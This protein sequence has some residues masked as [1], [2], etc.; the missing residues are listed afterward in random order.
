MI[1]IE[2]LS[3]LNNAHR[4]LKAYRII[5]DENMLKIT[6]N[7]VLKIQYE[8][9]K[10]DLSKRD[11]DE[12]KKEEGAINIST[13]IQLLIG[14]SQQKVQVQKKM[15]NNRDYNVTT[16]TGIDVVSEIS[17]FFGRTFYE[18]DIRTCNP[19]LIYAYCGLDLP[20]N[21]YGNNKENKTAINRILNTISKDFAI[22]WK[23]GVRKYK[24]TLKSKMIKFNFDERVIDFLINTF[25]EK[26]KDAIFNFCSAYEKRLIDNLVEILK[27]TSVNNNSFVRRHD[28]V[29]VFENLT[30]TQMELIRDFEFLDKKG[31][32]VENK[33]DADIYTNKA[34]K[35]IE[36]DA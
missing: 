6:H 25:F 26:S 1:Y 7:T 3:H 17:D 12:W 30:E 20:N 27:Q 31:W 2:V 33:N 4:E 13:F 29:L 22:E 15:V 8:W 21:F 10:E 16:Q 32:F 36:I 9:K 24:H 5:I 23:I 28:S 34:K 11:F 18:V 14:F 19:R 35:L